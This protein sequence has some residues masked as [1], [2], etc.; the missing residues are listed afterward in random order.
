[1]ELAAD[2][3][4]GQYSCSCYSAYT[5][6]DMESGGWSSRGNT[7][8][9]GIGLAVLFLVMLAYGQAYWQVIIVER[10]YEKR[11]SDDNSFHRADTVP[12]E[13]PERVYALAERRREIGPTHGA[14]KRDRSGC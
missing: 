10:K 3:S 11:F 2:W 5:G 1:M 13:H 14:G 4:L 8:M 9:Y 7:L 6:A 12:L